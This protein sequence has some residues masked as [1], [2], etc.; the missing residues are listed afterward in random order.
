LFRT[1][2]KP[3][4]IRNFIPYEVVFETPRGATFKFLPLSVSTQAHKIKSL[5][6]SPT[7]KKS[8]SYKENIS[9]G[10]RYRNLG[11]REI[12]LKSDGVL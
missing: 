8:N 11:E 6:D 1:Q 5:F 9:A 12:F 7:R 10:L 2:N 4:T 3:E